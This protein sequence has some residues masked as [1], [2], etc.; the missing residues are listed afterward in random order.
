MATSFEPVNGQLRA[1]FADFELDL[2]SGE[3]IRDGRRSRLQGQPFQVLS[4]LLERA[5]GVVTREELQRRLWPDETFVD[6]DHGLNKAIAKLREA[7]EDSRTSSKLIETIPRRGYRLTAE[8]NWVGTRNG[9]LVAEERPSQQRRLPSRNLLAGGVVVTLLVTTTAW[10]NRQTLSVWLGIRPAIQSVAVLPLVN[11]SNDPAQEYLA[12]G[13]TEQL[14]TDLSYAKPLRVLSR[15]STIAFKGSNLSA[16]Q[17]AEQLHVDALIE[18]TVLRANDTARITV[19]LTAARPERQLWA[20]SYERSASDLILLQNQLAA[21]AVNQMRAQLTPQGKTQLNLES[22]INPQ[23]YDEYLQ[24]QFFLHQETG[25][26]DKAIPHLERAIQLDPH[27]AGAYAAMGQ[28]WAYE[29]IWGAPRPA[30]MAQEIYATALAYSQKAVNLDHVSSEAYA[31]LGH[32]LMQNHRWNEG[33]AALRHS[34]ELDPNNTYATQY[35]AILLTQKGRNDEA[36]RVIRELALANPV[37]IDFRRMYAITLFNARRYDEAIAE[38]ERLIKLD[39]DHLPTYW[40]YAGALV[41]QG[42]FQEAEA[43]FARNPSGINPGVRALLLARQGKVAAARQVLKEN[44]SLVDP[45]IAVARYLLGE[46]ERGLAELDYL[47][48]DAWFIK[49]YFLRVDPLFDP[50]RND[51]RFTEIVKKTGLLDN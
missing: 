8:V 13:I 39:P 4:V 11:L 45:A 17:I 36:V 23:A 26:K 2:S 40:P 12:D 48:N 43:A 31:S 47:A 49:T 1:Q 21:D 16:P 19:R 44:D 6:F 33:E 32:S 37:A 9:H 28:A 5:G 14:I 35:L 25:Q 34:R 27:F 46:Q 15:S 20:A 38:C 18:G 24:A 30:G 41:Q 3:L 51:P 10:F 50:M 7:L 22:K 29:G 42:R